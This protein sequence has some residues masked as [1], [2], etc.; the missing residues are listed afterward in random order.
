[1]SN[2]Q[3]TR[4]DSFPPVVKWLIIVNAAVFLAQNTIGSQFALTER[5]ALWPIGSPYFQPYQIFTH[6]FT[7]GSIGHIFFNMFA[8]WMFGKI[9]ENVW[10]PKRFLN[11]YI[12]S[13]IG[14]AVVHLTVQYFMGGFSPAVG[15]SG[16]IMGV[17]VAFC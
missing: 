12:I 15:A 9:L 2:F 17:L 5:F 16:A 6:M 14:A 10:G 7:H 4:P 8:L 1:M 13:G 11:F 3:F